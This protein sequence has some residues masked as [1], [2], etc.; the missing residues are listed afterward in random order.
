V[1]ETNVK[2]PQNNHQKKPATSLP[3][4]TPC[5]K[6][7]RTLRE[8]SDTVRE[9]KMLNQT[10]NCT[11]TESNEC[12]VFGKYIAKQ[13]KLLNAIS[14]IQAQ[15]DIQGVVTQYRMS[16]L[17][18]EESGQFTSQSPYSTSLSSCESSAS[19]AQSQHTN[20]DIPVIHIVTHPTGEAAVC[21]SELVSGFSEDSHI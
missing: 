11:E 16:E 8:V 5:I 3:S 19:P 21:L 13:L 7:K 2:A 12:D 20:N 17:L 6:K 14:C 10:I 4:S 18:Q 1:T 9:L 15:R